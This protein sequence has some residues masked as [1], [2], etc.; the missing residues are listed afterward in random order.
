MRFS[1]SL[2]SAV[3]VLVLSACSAEQPT[4]QTAASS[5][6]K[7]A[8]SSAAASSQAP[9]LQPFE[10]TYVNKAAGYSITY[11]KGWAIKEKATSPLTYRKSSGTSFI[12]PDDYGKDT[13]FL[14]GIVFVEPTRKPCSQ[15]VNPKDVTLNGREFIKGDSTIMGSKNFSRS[16]MYTIETDKTCYS[17]LLSVRGCTSGSDC[18]NLHMN[19]FD[20]GELNRTFDRMV[21]SFKPLSK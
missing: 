3:S 6:A 14:S 11:P 2:L 13:T 12:T 18:G 9:A 17:I 7:P 1:A 19:S 8:I 16:T 15:F 21:A 5:S 20:P 10:Q 4:G